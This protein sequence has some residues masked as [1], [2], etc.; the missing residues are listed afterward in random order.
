MTKRFIMTLPGMEQ[1]FE[2]GIS[3]V[4]ND[5]GVFTVITRKSRFNESN[6]QVICKADCLD[7]GVEQVQMEEIQIINDDDY[8]STDFDFI[9]ESWGIVNVLVSVMEGDVQ[10]IVSF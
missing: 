9:T 4:D 7:S 6:I 5:D 10:I 3:T 1:E 2:F 8:Y